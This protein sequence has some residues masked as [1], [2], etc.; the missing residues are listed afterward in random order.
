MSKKAKK[1]RYGKYKPS[2]GF[3]VRAQKK[4]L[5]IIWKKTMEARNILICEVFK[6]QEKKGV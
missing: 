1:K 6:C 4:R 5:G 2:L 3:S